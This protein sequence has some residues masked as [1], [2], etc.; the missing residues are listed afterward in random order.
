LIRT[1]K[2]IFLPDVQLPISGKDENLQ[3]V[4]ILPGTDLLGWF[5][6]KAFTTFLLQYMLVKSYTVYGI[7]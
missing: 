4:D 2:R 6:D 5:E 1:E 7:A 3:K